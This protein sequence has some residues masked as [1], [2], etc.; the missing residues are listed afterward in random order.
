MACW[1]ESQ[2]LFPICEGVLAVQWFTAT[3]KVMLC[4]VQTA[5]FVVNTLFLGDDD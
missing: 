2:E 4:E 5:R 3:E 1:T